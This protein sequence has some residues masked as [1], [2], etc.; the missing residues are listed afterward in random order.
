MPASVIIVGD[1]RHGARPPV[2]MPDNGTNF[3]F[4]NPSIVALADVKQFPTVLDATLFAA[5]IPVSC[6]VLE[7]SGIGT[8]PEMIADAIS[9]TP[10]VGR[11]TA[12]L[13][14]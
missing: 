8:L 3:V 14:P 13:L 4:V 2:L 9:V 11:I 10:T 12:P 7:V 1:A 5:N 6:R